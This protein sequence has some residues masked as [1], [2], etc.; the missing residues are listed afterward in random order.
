M[1]MLRMLNGPA[2]APDSAL[3]NN[4]T[5]AGTTRMEIMETSPLLR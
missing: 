3:I 2:A 1:G 5:A 4:K